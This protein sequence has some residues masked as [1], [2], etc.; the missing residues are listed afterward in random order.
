MIKQSNE[1]NMLLR[2]LIGKTPEYSPLS[3]YQVQ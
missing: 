3:L 1:T 2:E